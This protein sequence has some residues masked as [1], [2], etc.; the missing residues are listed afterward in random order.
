MDRLKRIKRLRPRAKLEQPDQ[1]GCQ[2]REQQHRK[3][4]RGDPDH[5]AGRIK[6]DL[7]RRPDAVDHV[8]KRRD[9]GKRV[10]EYIPA[11]LDH[12]LPV[13]PARDGAV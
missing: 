13:F 9:I 8:V 12:K 7:D 4:L 3:P 2:I 5:P 1:R 6:A 11:L 10:A